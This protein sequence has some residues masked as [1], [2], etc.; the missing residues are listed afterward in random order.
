MR[1]LRFFAWALFMHAAMQGRPGRAGD[2]ANDADN[3]MAEFDKRV[4]KEREKER[5]DRRDGE[6]NRPTAVT[7]NGKRQF[8]SQTEVTYETICELARVDV[9][10]NP[11]VQYAV[12]GPNG[13]AGTLVAGEKAKV[14]A[15]MAFDV[16]VT[17]NA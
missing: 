2:A 13:G 3:A 4:E 6:T 9:A 7:V 11:T 8:L 17:G 5:F 1:E 10:K 14:V 12:S 16:G 15:D